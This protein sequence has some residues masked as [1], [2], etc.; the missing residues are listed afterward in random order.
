MKVPSFREAGRA[1]AWDKHTQRLRWKAHAHGGV[2]GLWGQCAE[3]VHSWWGWWGWW[4]WAGA[5]GHAGLPLGD[6]VEWGSVKKGLT[7]PQF[8]SCVGGRP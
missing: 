2:S 4:G 1:S 8:S 6:S 7:P 5:P 3:E